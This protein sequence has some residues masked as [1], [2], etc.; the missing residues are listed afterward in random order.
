MVT[1]RRSPKSALSTSSFTSS[2]TSS[3][4]SST[5][6]RK[7]TFMKNG[8]RMK[9]QISNRITV[10]M[11]A[12]P[13]T[14]NPIRLH[15][16][17]ITRLRA[18]F[19]ADAHQQPMALAHSVATFPIFTKRNEPKSNLKYNWNEYLKAAVWSGPG[20]FIRRHWL[21]DIFSRRFCVWPLIFELFNGSD[22][23]AI[24]NDTR[25]PT[26]LLPP[27][28]PPPLLLLFIHFLVY[29][30]PLFFFNSF[31]LFRIE[32]FLLFFPSFSFSFCFC[33]SLCCFLFVL[34]LPTW[35]GEIMNAVLQSDP[36]CF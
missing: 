12:F 24:K 9:P 6:G 5:A 25:R 26:P 23:T 36:C 20:L 30:V 19:F 10:S 18:G 8:A 22:S 1:Q 21:I 17:P 35:H 11:T 28:L 14:G 13:L 7:D 2:S 4:T 33:V 34:F 15:Y 3:P 16:H 32:T 31:V 29:F 27:P